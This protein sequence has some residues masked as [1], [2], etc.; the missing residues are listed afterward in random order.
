M[1]GLIEATDQDEAPDLQVPG[2]R[3][4]H[5]I[6]VHFEC[7]SRGVERVRRPA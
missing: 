1:L 5:A 2:V 6:T 4:V 7:R 3:R